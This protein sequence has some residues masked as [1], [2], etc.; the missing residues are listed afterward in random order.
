MSDSEV[1]VCAGNLGNYM[2]ETE[3][4]QGQPPMGALS[5]EGKEEGTGSLGIA[6]VGPL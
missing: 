3:L 6:T 2:A 1:V 4:D 5:Q